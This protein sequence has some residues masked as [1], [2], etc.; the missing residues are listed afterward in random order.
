MTTLVAHEVD[1]RWEALLASPPP[2]RQ[3]S[4]PEEAFMQEEM[5]VLVTLEGPE[6]V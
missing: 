1:V 4:L 5:E 2:H 6:V 3:D